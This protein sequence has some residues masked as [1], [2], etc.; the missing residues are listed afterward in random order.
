MATRFYLPSTGAAAVTPALGAWDETANAGAALECVTTRISSVMASVTVAKGTGATR[1]LARQ[2]VSKPIGA[3]TI[4]A[5]TVKGQVRALESAINDNLDLVPIR[6]TVVSNDGTALRG[7]ILALGDYVTVLEFGTA[8]TNRKIA[9][10]DA[11]S[12]VTAQDGDRIVIELGIKNSTAGTSVSGSLS[13]GDDS[14]TDLG[15]N[16]TDTS[17]FNPWVELSNTI[18]FQSPAPEDESDGWWGAVGMKAANFALIAALAASST[19]HQIQSRINNQEEDFV[20]QA[21]AA[22]SVAGTPSPYFQ[23]GTNV[24]RVVYLFGGDEFVPTA[25]ATPPSVG[26]ESRPAFTV[27]ESRAR[28]LY[29]YGDEVLPQQVVPDDDGLVWI[30]IP[31][32]KTVRP[33]AIDDDLPQQAA[34]P[35]V[36][37]EDDSWQVIRPKAPARIAQ[38][39]SLEDELP[40]F[41]PPPS[42]VSDEDENAY[43]Q[44]R[45]QVARLI[46]PVT[47][48]DD[49]APQVVIPSVVFAEDQWQPRARQIARFVLPV[50]DSD[51]FAPQVVAAGIVFEEDQWPISLKRPIARIIQPFAIEDVLPG[52]VA[53]PVVGVFTMRITGGPVLT[54]S[55]SGGPV[56]TGAISGGPV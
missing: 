31:E 12:S 2:Y 22:P 53:P 37:F 32:R 26:E 44:R 15:E 54:G 40:V 20:P 56:L 46:I 23:Q 21:A 14:G 29:L 10:G 30:V 19:A 13:F 24:S 1:A 7:T 35:S 8:L 36:V 25:G 42:L 16:T 48:A 28:V 11:T 38:N 5:G 33:I 49:F 41:V 6:I 18:T 17:A 3:Q 50:T 52:G 55:I 45:P 34:G 51:D 9:D 39:P 4:S 43:Q 27:S 47:D